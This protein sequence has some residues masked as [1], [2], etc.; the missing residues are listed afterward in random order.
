M[1]YPGHVAGEFVD[2]SAIVQFPVPRNPRLLPALQYDKL[3]KRR[4]EQ[5]LWYVFEKESRS[6]E[7]GVQP[8]TLKSRG[9]KELLNVLRK[10]LNVFAVIFLEQNDG[11]EGWVKVEPIVIATT[12]RNGM[13]VESEQLVASFLADV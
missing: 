10:F 6:Q 2:V 7:C 5:Q 4:S 1:F 11:V 8:N 9:I 12:D 13:S 3:L